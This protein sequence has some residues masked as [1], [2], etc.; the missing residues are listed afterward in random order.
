MVNMPKKSAVSPGQHRDW[1]RRVEEAGESPPQI[2]KTDGYDVR[3]VRKHIDLARQEREL[4]EAR[5]M[6]LR[7][8]LEEHYRDLVALVGR[9]DSQV[10]SPTSFLIVEEG[11]RMWKAL[12]EHLPRSVLWKALRRWE[13]LQQERIQLQ[14]NAVAR[15]Q[16]EVKTSGQYKFATTTGTSGLNREG[17]AGLVT[18]RLRQVAEAS[19]ELP[20]PDT[21]RTEKADRGLVQ[22]VCSARTCATVRRKNESKT[23]QFVHDLQ[24]DINQWP[25]TEG[26]K[27]TVSELRRL[28]ETLREELATILLRRVVPGRCK[29]CPF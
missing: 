15:M 3:T 29:Y 17:L 4:R 25:E 26:M 10:T 13:H 6:V 22:L 7:R 2:A 28:T 18:Y 14:E 20:R 8:A 9:I 11:D 19:G 23:K 27:R 1:L 5:S 21:V 12:R 24:V 16:E